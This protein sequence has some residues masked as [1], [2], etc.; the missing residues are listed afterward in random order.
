MNER[1]KKIIVETLSNVDSV[2]EAKVIFET[3]EETVTVEAKQKPE[4]ILEIVNR[5]NNVFTLKTEQKQQKKNSVFSDSQMSR[6]M[7]LAGIKR[8]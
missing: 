1:Q 4:T 8:R 6:N 3:A 7:I 5:N 2:E